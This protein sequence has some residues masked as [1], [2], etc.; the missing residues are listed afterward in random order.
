METERKIV[1]GDETKGI[2][3]YGG[4]AGDL[5]FPHWNVRSDGHFLKDRTKKKPLDQGLILVFSQFI[6]NLFEGVF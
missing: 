6:S 1:C 2:S 4:Q 5:V 3:L